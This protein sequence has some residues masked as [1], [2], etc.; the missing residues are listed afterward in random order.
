[1]LL[2]CVVAPTRAGADNGPSTQAPA[3][4]DARGGSTGSGTATG[5]VN[6]ATPL[7]SSG[8]RGPVDSG[9]SDQMSRLLLY[10]LG[11]VLLG[12]VLPVQ[13]V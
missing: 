10:A 7:G 13:I 9:E 4:Y 6:G 2:V 8:R 11:I 1:V 3:A 12:F 5:P